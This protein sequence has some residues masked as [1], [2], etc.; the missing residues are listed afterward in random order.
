MLKVVIL[1]FFFNESLSLFG[2]FAYESR[3]TRWYCKVNACANY[4]TA[5]LCYVE[6]KKR[7]DD[8]DGVLFF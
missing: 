4:S 5:T 8:E 7:N 6:G 2:G 3:G 1:K